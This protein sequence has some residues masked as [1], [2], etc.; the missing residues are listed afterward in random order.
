MR[1]RW[2]ALSDV[3]RAIEKCKSLDGA[4]Y[5]LE[6]DLGIEALYCSELVYQSYENNFLKADLD[7]FV[8]LGRPY[9]SPVGLYHADNLEV[10]VDSDLL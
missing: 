8:G 4:K 9:I 5:D 6:F 10:I 3:E 7:D 1:P 2:Y